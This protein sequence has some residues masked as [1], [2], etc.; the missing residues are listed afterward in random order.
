[1]MKPLLCMSLLALLAAPLAAGQA[2]GTKPSSNC[3]SGQAAVV[4]VLEEDTWETSD[5]KTIRKGQCIAV[6]ASVETGSTGSLTV[7]SAGRIRCPRL[8]PVRMPPDA[9]CKSQRRKSSWS[10]L[11]LDGWRKKYGLRCRSLT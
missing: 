6:D 7:F 1:M 5:G 4:Q 2:A 9:G 11:L 8:S 10:I 3:G